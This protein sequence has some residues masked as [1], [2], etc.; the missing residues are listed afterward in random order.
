MRKLDRLYDKAKQLREIKEEL[1]SLFAFSEIPLSDICKEANISLTHYYRLIR[2]ERELTSKHIIKLIRAL[3]LQLG[4]KD[5]I[6]IRKQ[7]PYHLK[8]DGDI[9]I[10]F[11]FTKKELKKI[12][13]HIGLDPDYLK[14]T[15]YGGKEL[16]PERKVE[17]LQGII[18]ILNYRK[19]KL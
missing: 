18:D 11:D 3:I 6:S 1:P 17:A 12:S 9:V 16:P 4:R 13:E 19:T 7:L 14:R 8:L 5:I 10:W 2:G 15:F